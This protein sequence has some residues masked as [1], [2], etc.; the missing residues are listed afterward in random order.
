M[1]STCRS[2]CSLS[3]IALCCACSFCPSQ[4]E[5]MVK[6]LL[7][8]EHDAELVPIHI[9]GVRLCVVAPSVDNQL[10]KLPSLSAH[11]HGHTHM[12]IDTTMHTD[13]KLSD[14]HTHIHQKGAEQT[15]ADTESVLYV[16]R[17]LMDM[18]L[19]FTPM[20]SHTSGLF[21]AKIVKRTA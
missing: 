10:V 1:Y 13:T 9:E 17:G 12:D 21:V 18:T 15:D 6:W 16:E 7:N 3:F 8:T 19:R 20:T 2:D 11:A 4:N 5:D 14:G